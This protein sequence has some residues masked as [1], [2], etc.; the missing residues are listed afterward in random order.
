MMGCRCTG[1]RRYLGALVERIC[2][3]TRVAAS[4]VRVGAATQP[5]INL[6][7]DHLLD[8]PL[9][10]GDETT[11]Q[12]LKEPGR[13]AQAKSYMWVQMTQGSG[14]Q[15]TGPPI[16]LFGYSP[17]RST[18]AAVKL[19]AGLRE[20]A[21]LMTDGY[22]V[23]DKIERANRLVHLGCWA[24]ARRYMVDALQA[25]PKN[26]RGPEQPAVQFIELIAKLYAVESRARKLEMDA[27][28]RLHHR[29]EH[30]VPVIEAIKALLLAH[31]HAVVP[32]SALGK[33]LHY[34]SSQWPKLVRYV[35][36]ARY[37]IDNNPC[38]NS[39]RPFVVGRRGW[40]FSDTVAGANAS[41][42]L[43]SLVQTCKANGID[44]YRY[45]SALFIA[46]PNATTV[47]DYEALLPWRIALP[48]Q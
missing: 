38:E 33:A 9:V 28:Q 44:S 21:V 40:L 35:E 30:S 14:P 15:G 18:D 2:R 43:Y 46:L 48:A 19:Y 10:F 1:R 36:D 42:N 41:A 12:V 5:V 29:Q 13:A 6:M 24:H 47:D 26:A 11:V 22:E 17:S 7:R 25:L 31:L 39:I 4:I 8:S 3:A 27:Q 37:P 45:L 34:F 23:Y 16:R 32:G 20:G